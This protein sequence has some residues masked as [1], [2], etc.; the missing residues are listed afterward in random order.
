[1]RPVLLA[2]LCAF[3]AQSALADWPFPHASG[4]VWEYSLT[5]ATGAEDTAATSVPFTRRIASEAQ[6]TESLRVENLIE[7]AVQSRETWQQAAGAAGSR[8]QKE[9]PESPITLLPVHFEP[10]FSWTYTGNIAGVDFTIPQTVTGEE[11]VSVAA[12][13]FHALRV[14]GEQ[15][16]TRRTITNRWFVP[17]V[18]WVKEL[19]TERAPG[20]E[21]LMQNTLELTKL[22]V[23]PQAPAAAETKRLEVSVSTSTGAGPLTVISADA[24]QIVARWRAQGIAGTTKLKAIWIAE[25][26]GNIAPPNYTVDE[27]SSVLPA[28]EAVGAFTLSRPV[29]GWA[30]GKY[31]VE[32]YLDEKLAETVKLTIAQQ[33]GS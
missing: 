6:G 18:G 15:G 8:E 10:G 28:D 23:S 17:S 14:H 21:L 30:A 5:R 33:S 31:R 22:P 26:T 25:D 27:T 19:V 29:D 4:T 1:M 2:C 16:T 32:F 11:E 12:G 3:A 20:G 9:V 24:L 7:G 13:T